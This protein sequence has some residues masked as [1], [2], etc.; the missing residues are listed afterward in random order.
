MI[1]CLN[2]VTLQAYF[3][4]ELEPGIAAQV[5]KHLAHCDA[6]AASAFEFE[7][8]IELMASAFED[9][10]PDSIPSEHL[11]ARIDAALAGDSTPQRISQSG[12]AWRQILDAPLAFLKSLGPSRHRLAYASLAL[13]V[14]F[15]GLWIG[16]RT[17][18]FARKQEERVQNP[19]KIERPAATP[20]GPSVIATDKKADVQKSAF[21]REMPRSRKSNGLRNSPGPKEVVAEEP[22]S[23]LA[24]PNEEDGRAA[25]LAG[26]V[27]VGIFDAGMVRH[28]DK[29]QM[30]LR[31]FR[32]A[33]TTTRGFAA[34][35]D[36]EKRQSKSLLY[37]NI[38][39]RRD[40]ENSGNLPAEEVLSNLEPVL[41][42]ISNLPDRPSSDEVRSI[43]DRI[44]KKEILGLLQ[45]YSAPLTA[46]S[47][48]PY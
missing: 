1:S 42:D 44:H 46:T 36:H 45:V 32:N 38:L 23:P 17:G 22:E 2:E 15:F 39:L 33:D 24:L 5:N 10:L 9:E 26:T 25:W 43:K 47:Y 7:R 34:D 40:A 30:L 28:F 16:L 3:D 13:L 41:L 6:C 4:G 20:S 21:D 8:A 12:W 19:E 31:S 35:L 14:V 11:R 29:A 48:Q 37:Q 18:F 27:G